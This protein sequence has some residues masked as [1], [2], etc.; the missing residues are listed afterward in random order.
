MAVPNLTAVTGVL[1]NDRRRFYLDENTFS[2]LYMSET[3]FLSG[4]MNVGS[5]TSDDPDYKMFEYRASW[6]NPYLTIGGSAN[7]NN[8]GNPAHASGTTVTDVIVTPS[9]GLPAITT[10]TTSLNGVVVDFWN[11]AGTTYKG[12]AIITGPGSVAGKLNFQGISNPEV[13]AE[14]MSNLV[15]TDIAYIRTS[16]AGEGANSPDAFSDDLEVVTNS[17]QIFRTPLEMTGTLASANLRG[18]K[19]RQRLRINKGREH[20]MKLER[21]LFFGVKAG[22][23]GG[24]AAGTSGTNPIDGTDPTHRSVGGATV[25]TTMGVIPALKRYGR[26]STSDAFQNVFNRSGGLTF[27]NFVDDTEKL[28]Q[29]QPGGGEFVAYCGSGAYSYWSKITS[30]LSFAAGR[31]QIENTTSE[32]GLHVQK[33]FAPSGVVI[34]LVRA[35]ALNYGP[36]SKYMVIVNP[37]NAKLVS[38]RNN[39]GEAAGGSYSSIAY[40]TNIKTDNGYDGVKDEYF[41]DCG[42]ALTLMDSHALMITP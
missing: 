11:A 21:A 42:V 7:W 33:V 19:E 14:T 27:D 9:T 39:T 8:S 41:S 10:T 28:A 32:L 31:I 24:Y 37:D 13:G 20:M 23:I 5:E 36:T 17:T 15:D 6:A 30:D 22:G 12:T 18:E 3:P 25:R 16:A 34:N 38:Y 1:F 4:L 2:E 40:N 26:S 29:Y 35:P